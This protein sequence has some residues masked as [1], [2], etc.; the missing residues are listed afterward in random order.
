VSLCV[1]RAPLQRKYF[2]QLFA[3][4]FSFEKY[5]STAGDTLNPGNLFQIAISGKY[6]LVIL[7][8]RERGNDNE[9]T[10][11]GSTQFATDENMKLHLL[12]IVTTMS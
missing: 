3:T 5:T 12:V 9:A 10:K 7:W 4:I 8:F 1:F 2:T 11:V 6:P